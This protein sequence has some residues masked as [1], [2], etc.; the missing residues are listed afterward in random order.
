MRPSYPCG[1]PGYVGGVEVTLIGVTVAALDAELDDSRERLAEVLGVRVTEW[2]PE[3]G[4]WDRDAVEFFRRQVDDGSFDLE[5]GPSYVVSD[6]VLV[7][8]AGFFGPPDADDEVEIG[9][10]VCRTQRGRGIATA[11]VGQLCGRAASG[12]CASVRARTTADNVA[13][14]AVLERNRFVEVAR[15]AGE[16]G[17]TALLFRRRLR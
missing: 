4:E 8:S 17:S 10:S 16:D 2:P 15:D 9:Y 6:G 7:A 3:G 12:G 5:W 13:S 14:I 1:H 11:A